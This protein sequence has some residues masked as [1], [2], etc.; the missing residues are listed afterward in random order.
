MMPVEMS[1]LVASSALFAV[2]ILV[3]ALFRISSNS[4]GFLLGPRDGM[5]DKTPQCERAR[6]ANNN[7]IE[8]MIM[9]IP[10]IVAAAYLD[11]FNSV[12]ALGATMFFWGR[13]AFAPLYWFGVPVLRTVAWTVAVLGL[14]LIFSQLVPPG[15]D[16]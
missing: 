7:M 8:A 10:L 14:A 16:F 12:T 2:M 3:Q 6:R 13:V 9:F 1:Y 4:V 5:K 11:R 15:L